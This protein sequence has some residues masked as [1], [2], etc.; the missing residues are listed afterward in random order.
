MKQARRR[1]P[2]LVVTTGETAKRQRDTSREPPVARR[3][4]R[5]GTWARKGVA[6]MFWPYHMVEF[7]EMTRRF[8][9]R[10]MN[11]GPTRAAAQGRALRKAA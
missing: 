1:W 7:S 10:L 8:V 9:R 11:A 3:E 4:T 6:I 5:P 2:T